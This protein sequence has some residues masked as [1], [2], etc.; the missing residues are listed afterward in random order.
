MFV[1]VCIYL[2][3]YIDVNALHTP[4]TVKEKKYIYCTRNINIY[5]N[6][7]HN[8]V[9]STIELHFSNT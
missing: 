2:Y 7:N 8:S 3:F 1:S 9:W 4:V 6:K 5:L